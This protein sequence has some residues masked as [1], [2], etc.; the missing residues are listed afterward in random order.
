MKP[1]AGPKS[2]RPAPGPEEDDDWDD[3]WKTVSVLEERRAA[4]EET[5]DPAAVTS[6]AAADPVD[7]APSAPRKA[8]GAQPERPATQERWAAGQREDEDLEQ[9]SKE[10]KD[11]PFKLLASLWSMVPAVEDQKSEFQKSQ[12]ACAGAARGGGCGPAPARNASSP[13]GA[14]A[15][16]A[17]R[18]AVHAAAGAHQEV[19]SA[20]TKSTAS[21][22]G[23]GS[24]SNDDS[25]GGVPVPTAEAKAAGFPEMP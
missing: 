23:D 9:M 5:K 22:S 18:G 7:T 14:A 25:Q 20:E 6:P 24:G 21:G 16:K 3:L 4:Y 12:R 17:W 19:L 8:G 2:Q 10:I 11:D 15:E 1:A 13:G